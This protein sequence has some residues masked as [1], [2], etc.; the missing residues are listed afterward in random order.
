MGLGLVH[1]KSGDPSHAIELY[2]QALS[3]HREVSDLYGQAN[4]L[5]TAALTLNKLGDRSQA[6]DYAQKASAIYLQIGDPTATKV[7]Q[8]LDNWQM[9]SSSQ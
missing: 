5:W 2:E 8:Q 1:D 7:Q 3:I 4:T 9:K 6:V